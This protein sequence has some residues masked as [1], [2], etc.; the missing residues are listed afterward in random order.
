[1]D[2]EL[3]SGEALMPRREEPVRE[4]ELDPL[5]PM[6]R[7][8]VFSTAIAIVIF[9]LTARIMLHTDK[10]PS[11]WLHFAFC[12]L[13]GIATSYLLILITQ[14]YTDYAFAPVRRIVDASATGHGTNVIAGISVGLESCLFPALVIC[15]S[16]LVSY[17]LGYYSGLPAVKAGIFGTAVCTM[18]MLSTAVYILSMNNFGPIADNAGGIV[19]MSGQPH[20][21]RVVTDRLDSCG[22]VTKAASKGY[23]VGGSALACFV[24]FQAF[25]D[26]VSIAL[27]SSFSNINLAR[28]ECVCGAVIGI[29]MIFV[30]AGWSMESVGRTAQE[31]VWEVRKQ[32]ETRPGIMD[33]SQRPDYARCVSIVTRAALREMRKP[34]IM[35]LSTPVLVGILFKMLGWAQGA[36]QLVLEVLATFMLFATLTGLLMAVFLDNAGG[37]WDNAKKFIESQGKKGTNEHKA[38]VTG[39]TVGDPF[40][41]T[42][43]PSLHV[44]ITSMST[45]IL[46][47]GPLFVSRVS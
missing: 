40:K 37:A 32:L 8:F 34:A 6:K 45:T 10:A 18:G 43:G 41:D 23:A 42:A 4:S 15:S 17:N 2:S 9:L 11:A 21:V 25:L 39:D 38:A 14:Y 24:L 13:F 28:V 46:V 27:K 20:A 33:G 26:E 5:V 22:N 44:I 3:E 29:T 16:L 1:M 36:P 7:G 12:G 19:E 35:A 47:L 31:V 30:F